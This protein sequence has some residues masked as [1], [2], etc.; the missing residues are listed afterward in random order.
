M[1][2]DTHLKHSDPWCQQIRALPLKVVPVLVE[3]SLIASI[4]NVPVM[5]CFLLVLF[6]LVS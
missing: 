4:E 6:C 1:H 2:K 5:T 3:A